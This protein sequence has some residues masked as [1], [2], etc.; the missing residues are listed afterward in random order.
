MQDFLNT[1]MNTSAQLLPTRIQL[2]WFGKWPKEMEKSFCDN[3]WNWASPAYMQNWEM[4]PITFLH[5]FLAV[6]FVK[7]YSR[8]PHANHNIHCNW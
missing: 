3:A 6:N 7:L 8:M 1:E 5:Q 2:R 4:F